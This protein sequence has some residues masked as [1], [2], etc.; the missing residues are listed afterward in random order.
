VGSVDRIGLFLEGLNDWE[1]LELQ[2]VETYDLEKNG[3]GRHPQ[4]HQISFRRKGDL[5]LPGIRREQRSACSCEAKD[6]TFLITAPDFHGIQSV[7]EF[8]QIGRNRV[9]AFRRSTS[10]FWYA[11]LK[12]GL[13]ILGASLGI[14][15]LLLPSLA[16][17]FAVKLTSPGP[18]IFKQ[19]RSGRRGKR[20][21]ILKFRSMVSN[22]PDLHAQLSGHNEME[23]PVF[24]IDK[25]P[26]VTP[27]G[28]FLRRTSL[29]E[30][31][32]LLNVIRGD[33]SI[34]GRA[35]CPI[36]RRR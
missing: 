13:D 10:D 18:V 1:R 30:I 36:T 17:A 27:F 3:P 11:F 9:L 28:E 29:D 5:R 20:F 19:V 4:G 7:P 21:T 22:A 23:G 14:I 31:P 16:I 12:R 8:E 35:P 26:R 25:D 2:I 34:V 15:I 6:S 24:K 33:M 32:Q